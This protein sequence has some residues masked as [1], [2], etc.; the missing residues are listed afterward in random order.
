MTFYVYIVECNDGTYYCGYTNDLETRINNH[1]NS[2]NK[3]TSKYT[4]SRRPVKL[5]YSENVGSK[6]SAMKR[7]NEIKQLT[8]K[9]KE[10]L[11]LTAV[12]SI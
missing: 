4:R 9:E 3:N 8:R 2:N 11:V 5:I 12:Q 6:S 1:N 7:E 10:E